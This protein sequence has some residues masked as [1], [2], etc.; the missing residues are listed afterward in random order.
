MW[1]AAGDE[2]VEMAIDGSL[3]SDV[4]KRGHGEAT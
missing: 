1:L 2:P 3:Q 4:L